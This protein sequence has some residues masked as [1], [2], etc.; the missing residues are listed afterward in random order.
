MLMTIK[1][2]ATTRTD[3]ASSELSL[4]SE[5]KIGVT[6]VCQSLLAALTPI[7]FPQW[8]RCGHLPS[9]YII[10]LGMCNL[11]TTSYYYHHHM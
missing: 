5:D 11:R 1:P 10:Q 9:D 6:V 4:L 7:Q 8:T 3:M 2:R